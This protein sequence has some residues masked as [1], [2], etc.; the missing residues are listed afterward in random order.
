MS[1]DISA[2]GLTAQR[3]R[4]NVIANNIA[5]ANST[6]TAAGEPYRRRSVLFQ[7]VNYSYAE[8]A[9]RV[10]GNVGQGVRV[11]G[12]VE[13][14]SEQAFVRVYDPSH[15][16]ADEEGYVLRPNIHTIIEMINLVDASRAYEANIAAIQDYR[17]IMERTLQIGT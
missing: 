9:R 14:R 17:R 11:A 8:T 6:V 12:I 7:P 2:T 1:I 3:I 13:D 5:N 4:M 10:E 15:P 16:Q